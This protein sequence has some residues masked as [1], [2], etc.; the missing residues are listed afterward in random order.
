VFNWDGADRVAVDVSR[1]LK[2]GDSYEVRDAQNL[3]GPPVARGTYEGKPVELPLD[4]TAVTQPTGTEV[5]QIKH[6]PREFNAFVLTT[7][8]PKAGAAPTPPKP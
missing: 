7:V 6:T 3:L 8:R 1:V 4:L 5:K 2:R